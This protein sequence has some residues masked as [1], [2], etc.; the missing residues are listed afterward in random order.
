[1]WRLFSF[2]EDLNSCQFPGFELDSKLQNFTNMSYKIPD[3]LL[4]TED[5]EWIRFDGDTATVG[6]TDFAQQQLGDIV[7]VEIET[8]GETLNEKDVFGTVEA[9][10][11]VADLFM[12][13]SGTI[14]EVNEGLEDEPEVVNSDPYG[15][16][17]M[18]KISGA[19]KP[20]TLLTPEQ[21]A[22]HV[23]KAQEG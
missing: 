1:M 14:E 8:E 5:H 13:V 10:K 23:E 11:T 6:V 7:Y 9:V 3:D 20:E 4:Y 16:G 15:G 22:A 18:V 12:P 2:Q 17:W 21:Y 19:S